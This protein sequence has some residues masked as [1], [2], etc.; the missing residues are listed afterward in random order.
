MHQQMANLIGCCHFIGDSP[1]AVLEADT[2]ADLWMCQELLHSS[3]MVVH[4]GQVERGLQVVATLG[5]GGGA[6]HSTQ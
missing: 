5:G 6:V 1:L 2:L 4:A 3:H